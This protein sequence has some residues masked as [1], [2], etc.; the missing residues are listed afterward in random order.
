VQIANASEALPTFNDA[1][2]RGVSESVSR[3]IA[4]LQAGIR[5]GRWVPGQRLVEADLTEEFQVPRGAVREALRILSGDGL[6]E[7][8]RNR[9]AR[10]RR[11]VPLEAAQIQ[12]VVGALQFLAADLLTA[13]DLTGEEIQDLYGSAANVRAA[14]QRQNKTDLM[15]AATAYQMCCNRLSGNPYIGFAMRR[16]NIEHLTG[17][18]ANAMS[19]E[20]LIAA[21]SGYSELADALSRK[22]KQKAREI[23]T[24]SYELVIRTFSGSAAQ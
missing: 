15:V 6:V 2:H 17:V 24:E 1:A 3:I 20:V 5:D 4:A 22:D 18:L 23:M 9:G 11:I 8:I 16:M 21:T 13:R 7:I 14:I 19:L 10:I 12:Q